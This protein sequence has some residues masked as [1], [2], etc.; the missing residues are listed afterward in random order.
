MPHRIVVLGI[1]FLAV[2]WVGLFV[3]MPMLTGR[4]TALAPLVKPPLQSEKPDTGS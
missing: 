2:V 3:I 1:I 4:D